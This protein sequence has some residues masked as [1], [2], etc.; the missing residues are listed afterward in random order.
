MWCYCYLHFSLTPLSCQEKIV[1][2]FMINKKN[3][4]YVRR[5]K[6]GE[7]IYKDVNSVIHVWKE[8]RDKKMKKIYI[9]YH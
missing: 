5:K 8:I 7:W 6:K 3:I 9:L 1:N 4:L 2:F